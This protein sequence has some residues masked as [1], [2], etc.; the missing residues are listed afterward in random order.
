MIKNKKQIF[1]NEI[2]NRI[3]EITTENY[4]V[5]TMSPD[6][7]KIYLHKLTLLS[8]PP[9]SKSPTLRPTIWNTHLFKEV[10]MGTI[11]TIMIILGLVLGGTTATVYAS[12]DDLPNQFLY[13]V[14]ILSENIRGDLAKDIDQKLELALQ[15]AE[16]RV[17][18][19][20]QLKANGLMP[21]E[22]VYANLQMQIE[23]AILLVTQSG[24]ENLEPAL[25]RIRDR[26]QIQ[27]KLLGEGNDDPILLRTR[28]ILQD[29]IQLINTGLGNLNG[30][31][32]EAQ[33]GWENI[34][35]MNHGDTQQTQTQNQNKEQNPGNNQSTTSTGNISKTTT[36]Q[37][38]IGNGSTEGNPSSG[39]N[40]STKTPIQNGS[41]KK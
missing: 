3:K 38:G 27:D 19:I 39:N 31:Y 36:P 30:F 17:E 35:L 1:D 7:K 22:A 18:E 4:V 5:P 16:T 12:E 10:R 26:L 28:T 23:R 9:V 41:G 33:N 20:N 8:R 6:I 21:P 34:P 2:D 37:V 14:K 29:R 13:P 25:L 15:N 32:Y 11:A 40:V 24:E